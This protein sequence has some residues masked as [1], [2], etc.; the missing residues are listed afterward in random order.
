MGDIV[1]SYGRDN[2][3]DS[4][5]PLLDLKLRN[6]RSG[7]A[8][9]TLEP[10]RGRLGTKPAWRRAKGFGRA[11]RCVCGGEWG[12]VGQRADPQAII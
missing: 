7:I 8:T 4:L 1:V 2:L 6:M 10:Q 11:S 5:F 3:P 12:G 9:T